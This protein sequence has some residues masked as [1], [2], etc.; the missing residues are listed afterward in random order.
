MGSSGKVFEKI[1][2]T[3]FLLFGPRREHLGE[4]HI[5]NGALRQTVLT[6]QGEERL[7]G[8]IQMWQTRGIPYLREIR[9][10]VAEGT[11]SAW[12]E[13]RIRPGHELFVQAL[14][15]WSAR[16]GYACLRVERGAMT[17][18][19]KLLRLPLMIHER[20]VMFHAICAT[21][22][23]EL[24]PWSRVID[25]ALQAVHATASSAGPSSVRGTSSS[26]TRRP[27]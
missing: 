13:D 10:R 21:S 7:G 19:E 24:A 15:Q 25:D 6:R 27:Q 12:Y 11:R 26:R 5:V 18:W 2:M 17:L 4:M 20:F 9:K 1:D 23:S 16:Q 14:Q 3:T 8:E 22:S